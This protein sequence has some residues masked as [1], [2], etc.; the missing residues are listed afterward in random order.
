MNPTKA[1]NIVPRPAARRTAAGRESGA[2]KKL[3]A[4][5][6]LLGSLLGNVLQSQAG[7]RVY[8]AV[9]TLRKG[10]IRLHKG[11]SPRLRQRLDRYIRKLDP[12]TISHVVRAFSIYFSLVNLAEE[13]HHHGL[14]RAQVRA[15]KAQWTG[16]FDQVLRE[17]RRQ[18]ISRDQLQQVLDR[19][20]YNPVITAHPTESKRHTI[21]EAL[22]RIFLTS[23][24]LDE[25]RLSRDDR[26]NIIRLLETQIQTLWKTDEVRMQRPNVAGEI[27]HCIHYFEDSLF[28]AVPLMYRELEQTIEK[29][30]GHVSENA[31]PVVVP[32]FMR[33]GSWVGGD[34]DGN[35]NVTP[36]VT[37]QAV[38]MH[39]IAALK[40]YLPRVA[41]L[42]HEL[43]HSGLMCTPTQEFLAGLE[44]DECWAQKALGDAQRFRHEPYRRKLYIARY[45]LQ[46]MLDHLRRQQEGEGTLTPPR[47]AYRSAGEFLEEL[48]RIRDSLIGHG[49]RALAD[50]GLKDLIRLVE[51]F[52]FFLAQLDIR[53]ESSRHTEAVAELC[54]A[55]GID[56][57]S[58]DEDG[59]IE[60]LARCIE[61]D[62]L[63]FDRASLSA[64]TRETL[65][66]FDVMARMRGEVSDDC[67]GSYVISMTHTASHVLEVMLLGRLAGLVGRKADDWYCHLLVSPLF[68]TI[69]DLQRIEPVMSRLLDCGIY[70][71]L[72]RSSGNVQE[73]ML[74]YSDSCKDGGI[75]ASAWSLYQAQITVARLTGKRGIDYRLFHGRGGTIGRGGGPTHESILSQPP[76]TVQG[77]IKFTEQ[78]EMVSYKYSNRETAVYELGVGITGLLKASRSLVA[79]TPATDPRYMAVMSDLASRGER[80]YRALVDETP[81]FLDYF[82]EATPVTE[83]G[84]L[85][86]G[87]RPS[88]RRRSDRTKGSIRAIPW[89]FGWAQSRHTLPAW[90]G[91]GSALEHWCADNP[92][93]IAQ[94]RT[95]Y[96]QWP[97]F[98]ALLSNTQMSLFKA[99]MGIARR[100]AN[101]CPDAELAN[102]IYEQ[103]RAE[104]ERTVR[105]ILHAA[106]IDH[107][108]D[109]NPTLR[110]SLSRRNPY[111]DPLNHIQVMLLERTREP[112]AE[113]SEK[114]VWVDPLL[115]SINAI[116]AGM[117]NTG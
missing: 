57:A 110:L 26:E 12:E 1:T 62:P 39:A 53:Q 73:I 22:R 4:R 67:F 27:R 42:S 17:F 40:E 81:R 68:E 78:G 48:Y 2:D 44:A 106:N 15:G 105:Q 88:H 33:F 14:R 9:E 77:R 28:Q 89:V 96:K 47:A 75:L 92:E 35:P 87:S 5:V 29:V 50:L 103:I 43:T 7:G 74:G 41:Q 90:Y 46:Q 94:L 19:L 36:E 71:R 97:F 21:M 56:Y 20:Y 65:E 82:Y 18:H 66:V 63:G 60:V 95:M 99:D 25:P 24:Q 98:R 10:T 109:E 6:K 101:L 37:A 114:A 91:I 34:R 102:G 112:K 115:R 111:M 52:G 108:I 61:G 85:N 32:S 55:N 45:R 30:Y 70:T 76:G 79:E 113:E 93:G 104:Y 23:Q 38:R 80:A 86:I 49:D 16:S 58:M 3:R 64:S 8:V 117:R 59:R 51:T 116:A 69:D 84:L 11:D 13:A 54:A 100:Y 72:L 83:I 31:E 107:L